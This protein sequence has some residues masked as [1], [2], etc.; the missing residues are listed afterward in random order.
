MSL[1][2]E[3]MKYFCIHVYNHYTIFSEVIFLSEEY[4]NV[5]IRENIV[6]I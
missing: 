6:H 3:R 2:L 1:H 4:Y 5:I